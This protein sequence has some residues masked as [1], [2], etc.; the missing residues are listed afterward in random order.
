M[1]FFL[2]ISN[3]WNFSFLLSFS[4]KA[5]ERFQQTCNKICIRVN[6]FKKIFTNKVPLAS[7]SEIDH[8]LKQQRKQVNDIQEDIKCTSEIAE[9]LAP[10]V[11]RQMSQTRKTPTALERYNS[12]Q[13]KAYRERLE[14]YYDEIENLW[15]S[16]LKFHDQSKELC[17][18][19]EEFGKVIY[20]P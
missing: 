16:Q 15:D 9:T 1:L 14:G 18:F 2:K 19:E 11:D 20:R 13:L 4:F 12:A 3:L 8:V 5:D 6:E 17:N 10:I 7:C